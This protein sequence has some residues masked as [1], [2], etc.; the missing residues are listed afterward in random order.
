MSRMTPARPEGAET[1]DFLELV[2]ARRS[3]R[4]FKPRPI[5]SP[6]IEA[7]LEAMNAAPSA[8]NLQAYQVVQ[9]VD[10]ERRRH[11]ARA[12]HDQ[13]FVA[14]APVVLV[15]LMDPA[16]SAAEYGSRGAS[17]YCCQDTAIA[18][19]Y[20]QLAAQALGLGSVWV[21]SFDDAAV[22]RAVD[23]P[24]TLRPAAL[25]AI[26]YPNEKPEPTPRRRLAEMV[27]EDAYPGKERR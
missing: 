12:A 17:L 22:R 11:L 14:E 19:A 9:V 15:F 2:R 1:T 7:I 6:K 21:G 24:E 18:A 23:A 16:R 5:E 27:H 13:E 25:V 3:V 8:G 26:G 20:T 10:P 4:A